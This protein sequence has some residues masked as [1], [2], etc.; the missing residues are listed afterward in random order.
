MQLYWREQETFIVCVIQKVDGKLEE[1][2][3]QDKQ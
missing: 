1:G 3:S 2:G